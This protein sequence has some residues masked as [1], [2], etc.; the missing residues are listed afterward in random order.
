LERRSGQTALDIV[1]ERFAPFGHPC[2]YAPW[3]TVPW[4]QSLYD[5][6][7][8]VVDPLDPNRL[9][10]NFMQAYGLESWVL[11]VFVVIVVTALLGL[12]LRRVFDRVQRRLG[13]TATIWDDSAFS[14]L[15]KP[16]RALVWIVGL[17]FAVEIIPDGTGFR[18]FDA[19][20]PIRDVA[21]IGVI[22]WFLTRF[23]GAAEHNLIESSEKTDSPLDRTTVDAIAKL[24][25]LSIIITTGL[26]ILQ[27]LGFS[28]SGVLAF[29]GVGGIAVGFAAKDLLSNFFGGLMIYLDRPFT[30][31]D[32][33]RSPD[34]SIEG[35]VENIGW[36]RTL[37]RKFDTRPLYV[38]N[39]TFT[40]I[41]V[42]NPSRM[43][44]R[45]I[46]ETMGI[47]YSDA[48]VMRAIV[49]EVEQLLKTHEGIENEGFMVI[50]FNAFAPSSLDFFIYCYTRTTGWAE[51][52]Q[53]K[54][55]VLLKILDIIGS[56]GA[57]IA[58]PT[59]TVHVPEAIQAHMVSNA[60]LPGPS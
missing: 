43:Q 14:A 37:I 10:P 24:L 57:E 52:H 4:N 60:P 55:D 32:W 38:P 9:L 33:V 30:V 5:H 56:H 11:Q 8:D 42:E 22:A 1:R 19:V 18:L 51:F 46:F 48:G 21:I 53:V 6:V 29:G 45:Q 36:R 59:S 25:R 2:D 54:Q 34:R 3:H 40:N 39:S 50:N 17:A 23:I 16:L 13:R 47:R 41:A 15:R 49:S 35:V 31:G 20:G 7:R 12:L 27:T 28:I 44:N 58:F 26:V